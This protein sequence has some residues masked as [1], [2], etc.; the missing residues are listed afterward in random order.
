MAPQVVSFKEHRGNLN[1]HL[2]EGGRRKLLKNSG[3]KAH[4]DISNPRKQQLHEAPKKDQS[5]KASVVAEE[6]LNLDAIAEERFFHNH[7][8]CIKLRALQMDD[9]DDIYEFP[10]AVGLSFP[11]GFPKESTSFSEVVPPGGLLKLQLLSEEISDKIEMELKE[12]KKAD[13]NWL[14]RR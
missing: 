4:S 1:S 12:K 9:D 2:M 7:Q 14:F 6:D 5:S 11:N 13:P 3:R 8:E 10:V